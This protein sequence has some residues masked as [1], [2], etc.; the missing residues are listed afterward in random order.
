MRA[1]VLTGHGGLEML[2]L[3]NDFGASETYSVQVTLAEIYTCV[4]E[5]ERA[6]FCLRLKDGRI[7]EA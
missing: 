1:F 2:Q 7:E 5:Y 4:L 3:R 6:E